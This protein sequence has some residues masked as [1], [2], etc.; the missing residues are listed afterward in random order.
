[1][2]TLETMKNIKTYEEIYKDEKTYLSLINELEKEINNSNQ[3]KIKSIYN[4]ILKC[5]I[6]SVL[7][8]YLKRISFDEAIYNAAIENVS[9]FKMFFNLININPNCN[10]K[11]MTDVAIRLYIAEIMHI[12]VIYGPSE[13]ILPEIRKT[14]DKYFEECDINYVLKTRD[15]FNHAG[16]YMVD[17]ACMPG[18]NVPKIEQILLQIH[19]SSEDL[20]DLALRVPNV[21][22]YKIEDGLIKRK[23]IMVMINYVLSATNA[24]FKKIENE[25]FNI[26]NNNPNVFQDFDYKDFIS[27]NEECVKRLQKGLEAISKNNSQ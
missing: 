27:E 1:M 15:D 14:R 21:N 24:N 12:R 7:Y 10:M 20:K 13:E 16:W 8:E 17:F 2:H 3:D 18:V 26:A 6:D 23:N 19:T 25:I 11:K 9:S 22:I 5:G 4:K